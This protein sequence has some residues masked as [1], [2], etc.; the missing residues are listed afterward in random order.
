MGANVDE[1]RTRKPFTTLRVQT[2]GV[3]KKGEFAGDVEMSPTLNKQP[4][5]DSLNCLLY[6]Y[7][8][9]FSFN[10]TAVP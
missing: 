1:R 4:F 7:E 8:E 3:W 9:L 2:I 5:L 6:H 10:F